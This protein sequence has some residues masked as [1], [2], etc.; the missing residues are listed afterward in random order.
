MSS[1]VLKSESKIK[2][3]LNWCFMAIVYSIYIFNSNRIK[4]TATI[5]TIT[6][7]TLVIAVASILTQSSVA[8]YGYLVLNTLQ[9]N[10]T[11]F[12]QKDFGYID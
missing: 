11:F 4:S 1:K 8:K 6:L 5:S 10:L 2:M 7:I 12:V 3:L 9:V